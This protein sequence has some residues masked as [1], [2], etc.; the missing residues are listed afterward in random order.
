MFGGGGEP[1]EGPRERVPE[2]LSSESERT[3]FPKAGELHSER[4]GNVPAFLSCQHGTPGWELGP[5]SRSSTSVP[6][7]FFHWSPGYEADRLIKLDP[8]PLMA[9]LIKKKVPR[10][11]ILGP[12]CSHRL[13]T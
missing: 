8:E 12:I 6:K 9:A 10:M 11:V 1:G 13:K 7:T 5:I 2:S 3:L 4:R